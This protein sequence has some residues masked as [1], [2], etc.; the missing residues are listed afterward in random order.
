MYSCFCPFLF[1]FLS[2][3]FCFKV[4]CVCVHRVVHLDVCVDPLFSV[5]CEGKF[6]GKST[7]APYLCHLKQGAPGEK[8]DVEEFVSPWS[9]PSIVP[10]RGQKPFRGEYNPLEVVFHSFPRILWY[11][12]SAVIPGL[13]QPRRHPALFCQQIDNRISLGLVQVK[14]GSH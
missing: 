13:T 10:Q 12:R 2:R 11:S 6:V 14:G 1:D 8:K 5:V 3:K 7:A 4:A 9:F